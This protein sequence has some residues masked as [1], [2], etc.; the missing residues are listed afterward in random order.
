MQYSLF[1]EL[2]TLSGIL[3]S[4]LHVDFLRKLDEGF[5]V[6][7]AC[8]KPRFTFGLEEMKP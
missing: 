2:E 3:N 6:K 5:E 4:K 7:F 1:T 8:G